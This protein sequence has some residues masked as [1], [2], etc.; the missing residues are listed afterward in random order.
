[1]EFSRRALDLRP[2][3]PTALT[4]KAT[5]ALMVGMPDR[6]LEGLAAVQAQHPQH[7]DAFLFRGMILL[8]S[9]DVAGA[10]RDLEV[11]ARLAPSDALAARAL[12]QAR[13]LPAAPPTAPTAAE[14]SAAVVLGGTLR[15]PEDVAKTLSGQETLYVSLRDPAGGPPLAAL[16][17]KP[18]PFPQAFVV[19]ESDALAM[20]GAPRPFPERM[21]LAVRIDR[22]GNPTT[23]D[24]VVAQV[25]LPDAARGQEALDLEL[26]PVSP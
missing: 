22:D 10:L 16:R 5:L 20:G 2:D 25:E 14:G 13:S 11:A 23:K 7:P 17:L 8:Q 19:R 9:G 26:K 6:A 18:G 3:D 15:L 4:V 24:D 21:L 1:M 12:A